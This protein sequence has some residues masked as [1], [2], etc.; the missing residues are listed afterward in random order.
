MKFLIDFL[1]DFKTARLIRKNRE[2]LS[3]MPSY[4]DPDTI[5]AAA[6]YRSIWPKTPYTCCD[7][8]HEAGFFQAFNIQEKRLMKAEKVIKLLIEMDKRPDSKNYV[9]CTEISFAESV[10]RAK[11]YFI[12]KESG[13]Y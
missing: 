9:Y 7:D 5:K 12:E 4:K 2:S 1:D 3:P 6:L 11:T 10:K 8:S 13:A